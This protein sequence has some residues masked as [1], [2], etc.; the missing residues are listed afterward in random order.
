MWQFWLILS[1]IF[2]IVEILT[3]GFLIF[4]LGVGALIAMVVSFFTSNVII[5]TAV[6]VLSSTILLFATRPFVNK[7]LHNKKFAKTNVYS[8]IGQEGIVTED[9]NLI[10]AT[11]QVKVGGETWSAT[12][13]GN[14]T[15]SKGTNIVVLA[16]NGVKLLVEPLRNSTYSN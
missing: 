1:G 2:F 3:V 8:I 10:E 4:W 5:Q 6:F 13:K 14:G 16:V 7:F 9:I 11:G 12:C 15:I